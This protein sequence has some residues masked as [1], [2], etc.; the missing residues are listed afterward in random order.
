MEIKY[1]KQAQTIIDN[2]KGFDHE[3]FKRWYEEYISTV[4]GGN[5]IMYLDQKQKIKE[6]E[7]KNN[8]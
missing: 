2:L 6:R 7:V 5:I 8:G 1:S 4:G 3:D